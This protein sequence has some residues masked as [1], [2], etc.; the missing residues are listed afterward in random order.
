[1]YSTEIGKLAHKDEIKDGYSRSNKN[2]AA[3]QILSQF[4]RQHVL[5]ISF[6]TIKALSK[7]K[8]LI[9]VE[10]SAMEM[11]AFSSHSTPPRVLKGCMKNTS[12]LTKLC[13]ALN[14]YYSDVMQEIL[15]FTMQTAVD[16]SQFPADPTERG[17]LSVAGFAQLE[18]TV[19]DIQQTDMFH[20]HRAR[21]SRTKAFCNSGPRNDMV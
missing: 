5:G 1:M 6:Q 18:I 14:I 2:D 20:I 13:A 17:L 19:V 4:G 9:V 7:V 12:M 21:C 15:S 8:N 11:P 3:Q 10:D 16:D